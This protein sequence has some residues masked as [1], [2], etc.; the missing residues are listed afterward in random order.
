VRS[1][2]ILLTPYTPFSTE[3]LWQQ[4]NLE[5]SVH[6]QSWS[7]ASELKIQSG[8]RI[9]KPKILFRKIDE[10]EIKKQKEKLQKT[11]TK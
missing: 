10:E 6:E 8:N 7:S 9:N 4:L 1:L 5:G 2:A 11:A 3:K